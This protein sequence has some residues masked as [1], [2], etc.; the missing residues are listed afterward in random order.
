MG[1]LPSRVS[2]YLAPYVMLGESEVGPNPYKAWQLASN[3]ADESLRVGHHRLRRW[4]REALRSRPNGG[5]R[6]MPSNKLLEFLSTDDFDLL[7][8]HLE[9]VT[10]TCENNSKDPT[11][12]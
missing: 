7:K 11:D 5:K 9:S 12:E 10:W 3:R 2:V 4:L 1:A 8:P 6:T